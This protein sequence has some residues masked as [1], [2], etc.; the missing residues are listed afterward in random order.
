MV[1]DLNA[2]PFGGCL[3][4][5]FGQRVELEIAAFVPKPGIGVGDVSHANG[6]WKRRRAPHGALNLGNNFR[7][8]AGRAHPVDSRD[9]PAAIDFNLQHTNRVQQWRQLATEN[10]VAILAI[11]VIGG[12]LPVIAWVGSCGDR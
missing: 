5:A 7:S 6:N 12:V 4:L 11:K 1:P 10:A 9:L 2:I 3:Q 8:V